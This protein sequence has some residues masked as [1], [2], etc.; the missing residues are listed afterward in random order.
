MQCTN[1]VGP[2]PNLMVPYLDYRASINAFKGWW[3]NVIE[4]SLIT[5]PLHNFEIIIMF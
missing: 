1:I 4:V 5:K 2:P 3:V